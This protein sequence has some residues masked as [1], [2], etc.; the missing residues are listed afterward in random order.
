MA[1][2]VVAL[3]VALQSPE[4]LRQLATGPDGMVVV[5]FAAA[6][7]VCLTGSSARIGFGGDGT[8]TVWVGDGPMSR[9]DEG[10]AAVVVTRASGHIVS[11]RVGAGGAANAAIGAIDLG[12]IA[13]PVVAAALVHLAAQQ[14][15]RLGRDALLAAVLADSA[16]FGPALIGLAKDRDRSRGLREAAAGWAGL[17]L[18]RRPDEAL[19]KSLGGLANDRDAPESV[20]RRAVSA[21]GRHLAGGGPILATLAADADPSI[22]VAAVQALARSGD[23]AARV[24]IRRLAG[25]DRARPQVRAEATTALGNRDAT[26]ADL[27][28]LRRLFES[29]PSTTARG[30]ALDALGEAGGADNARWLAQQASSATLEP[31][32][33]ARA[34]KAAERAGLSSAGLAELYR[35]Q[36][37]RPVRSAILD[38]LGRIADRTALATLREIAERDTDPELRRGAVRRLAQMGGAQERALLESLIER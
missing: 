27:A 24:A 4:L 18:A 16:D 14:D 25:D 12:R 8:E 30:A 11:V 28:L 5:R 22:A 26:P 20:R 37:E 3:L 15:G 35:A 19:A 34:V 29:L 23:P 7:G 9:C 33:R 6:P 32:L 38:A 17:A 10:L 21:L 1:A 36:T 13:A 31:S 2:V